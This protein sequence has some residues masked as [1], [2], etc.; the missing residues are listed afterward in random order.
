MRDCAQLIDTVPAEICAFR[1]VLPQQA[2]G[3]FVAPALPGTLRVAEIDFQTCVDLELR[4]L[5]HLRTLIPS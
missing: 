1:K 4:M 2:I 3:A 5:G